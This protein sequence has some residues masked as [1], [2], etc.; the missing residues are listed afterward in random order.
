MPTV[1]LLDTSLSMLRPATKPGKN[2][3][4]SN[5][6]EDG[7]TVEDKEDHSSSTLM[8]LAKRGVDCL[9]G[10]L[11]KNYR[12][13]HVCVLTYG[14][15]C[16]LVAPFTRDISEVRA[17]VNTVENFD[18]T[19]LLVG[20]RGVANYVHEQWGPSVPVSLVLVTDGALGHGNLSLQHLASG[21]VNDLLPFTFK[22][23][24]TV[25]C[26]SHN[27]DLREAIPA[28]EK[29][30]QLTGQ[31]GQVL[32]PEG[33]DLNN[34]SVE[35]CVQQLIDSRYRPFVGTLQ[36]GDEM[37]AS[38]TLC[39]PPSK[40]TQTKDFEVVEA[41]VDEKL[42][43]QGFLTLA[44]V[45]SPPVVSRHLMLPYGGKDQQQQTPS[46]D[47]DSRTPSL[48]VF[49]HGALRVENLCAVVQVSSNWFGIIFSH[50]DSKKKSSLMLA[51][52]EPGDTPV[53]W[54]GNLRSL[55]PLDEL[56]QTSQEP[57]PVKLTSH[58][59]SYSS[60]PVVWIKQSSLQS[61]IQKVLRHARK[62]P[63][64]TPHFYKEL[65]RLK[66]AALCIGF[67]ELLEGVASIFERECSTLPGSA[68]PDCTMQLAHAASE[69]RSIK[70]LSLD[71]TISPMSTKYPK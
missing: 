56:N 10:H 22:S 21:G 1:I 46:H 5:G 52:F 3:V 4:L 16:D 50:A 2:K 18:S 44:D 13:E 42:D 26:I 47:D 8:D 43:I 63:E 53:P 48:C 58:R 11:E 7:E 38:V 20:L 69:L 65:N 36:L 34:A 28:Y 30:I 37:S 68:H 67:H 45:A 25:L 24:S 61:D 66:K 9:L 29:L 57:F 17:K 51:L 62:L 14:S 59:P 32:A 49:L 70:A 55:G 31:E 71:Y 33:R 54:L 35:K 40:Y 41:V 15:Q 6:N 27:E 64:K 39:P 23:F 19:H 60:S 12:M